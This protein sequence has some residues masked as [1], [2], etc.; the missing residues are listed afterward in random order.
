MLGMRGIKKSRFIKNFGQSHCSQLKCG[1]H[2]WGGFEAM[3]KNSVQDAFSLICLIIQP[4]VDD[5]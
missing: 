4:G 3:V 5:E 2:R 1:R